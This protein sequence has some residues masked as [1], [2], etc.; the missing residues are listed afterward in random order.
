MNTVLGAAAL[1]LFVPLALPC[2]T[3]VTNGGFE[4]GR[5]GPWQ[6][7]GKDF[8]LERRV[9]CGFADNWA[10]KTSGQAFFRPKV[11]QQTFFVP[12]SLDKKPLRFSAQMCF[13]VRDGV[14]VDALIHSDKNVLQW[15]GRVMQAPFSTVRGH[16]TTY[17][18]LQS[19][20]L[21]LASGKY[22]L[23]LATQTDELGSAYTFIDD[24]MIVPIELPAT[25]IARSYSPF[26][27]RPLPT[28][29]RS[30]G[31]PGAAVAF[32]LSS[33]RL[34]RGV[35]LPGV[36]GNFW[37]DP[38]RGFGVILLG[39]G[40]AD[41]HGITQIAL[42]SPPTKLTYYLQVLESGPKQPTDPTLGSRNAWPAR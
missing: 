22:L 28:V 31:R 2:Q 3:L 26:T 9:G 27:G 16:G 37:L 6:D 20:P 29:L 35:R 4:S 39:V 34:N 25:T 32:F 8:T 17:H 38:A 40:L 23:K 19:P 7:Q 18:M 21:R 11:I 10:L 30:H 15:R 5:L 33:Q 14:A 41:R 12:K 42:P 1:L 36:R 13:Y 24:V